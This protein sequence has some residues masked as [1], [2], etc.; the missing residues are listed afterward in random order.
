M[1]TL[2]KNTAYIHF[3]Y[4]LFLDKSVTYIVLKVKKII[5]Y[6]YIYN[7]IYSI[8]SDFCE[9]ITLENINKRVVDSL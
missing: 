4:F 9:N 8:L 1:P 6:T 3:Q 2:Y 7:L 5:T